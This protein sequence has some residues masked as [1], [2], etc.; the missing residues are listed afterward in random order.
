MLRY[1]T[2]IT[3]VALAIG[4]AA[5]SDGPYEFDTEGKFGGVFACEITASAGITYKPWEK[6]WKSEVLPTNEKFTITVAPKGAGTTLRFGER[7]SAYLYSVNVTEDGGRPKGCT[8]SVVDGSGKAQ[9]TIPILNNSRLSCGDG[10][11]KY[12]FEMDGPTVQIS[13]ATGDLTQMSNPMMPTVHFI[14]TGTC[15]KL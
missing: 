11:N 5:A 7:T 10:F 4:S 15:R 9:D 2:V 14:K 6:E 13:G 1:L 3:T 12:L 8:N